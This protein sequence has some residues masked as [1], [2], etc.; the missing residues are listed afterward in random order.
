LASRKSTGTRLRFNVFKRDDFTCQYCGRRTPQVV[1]ELD[2]VVPVS[3]GGTN[4]IDNLITS[5]WEC[6]RGKA[7]GLLGD[8]TPFTSTHE[9]TISI[10]ERELQL[11]EYNE[12]KR[13]QREREDADIAELLWYWDEL[14]G[15]AARKVPEPNI[16]RHWLRIFAVDQ[17][18]D[19][20]EIAME[21]A[22]D[23]RGCKYMSGILRNWAGDAQS[24]DEE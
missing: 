6:N 2:H 15:R 7:D 18:K 17:I 20:M 19:A 16:L 3:A 22:G 12:V 23:W 10:L 9:K 8:R 13:Q 1:L 4:D 24:G 21:R 11:K 5:C 14:A